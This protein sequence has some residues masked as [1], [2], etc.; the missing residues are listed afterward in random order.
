M[1]VWEEVGIETFDAY[2]G[3]EEVKQNIIDAGKAEE[4]DALMNEKFLYGC[5]AE[6]FNDYLR[7]EDDEI[8]AMLGMVVE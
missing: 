5:E 6:E 2:S 7:H 1:R 8:Y 3:A 4:F